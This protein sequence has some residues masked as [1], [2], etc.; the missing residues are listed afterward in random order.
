MRGFLQP[1]V[2]A[3]TTD[4][5]NAFRTLGRGRRAKVARAAQ[6]TLVKAD[7]WGRGDAVPAD[8]ADAIE[9]AVKAATTPKKK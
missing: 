5:Q 2:H 9:R 7:Q 6:T 3:P 1:S 4:S 8:L